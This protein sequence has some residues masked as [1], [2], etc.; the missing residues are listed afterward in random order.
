MIV[1]KD[2][3]VDWGTPGATLYYRVISSAG[4]TLIARTNT[5]V[6]EDPNSTG[7]YHVQVTI[8][9]TTWVGRVIWDDGTYYAGEGFSADPLDI[10]SGLETG[11][12]I[13]EG[14]KLISAVLLGECDGADTNEVTFRDVNDTADRVVA[15][16]D[17]FGN[18]TAVTLEPD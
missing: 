15:T 11:M 5:N 4:T 17:E 1:T 12:T 13:R 10:A 8:W 6:D 2:L 14:L 7:L 3:F 18:R 16:V 9:N